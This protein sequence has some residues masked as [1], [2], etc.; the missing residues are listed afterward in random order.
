MGPGRPDPSYAGPPPE[1]APAPAWLSIELALQGILDVDDLDE[2]G[3]GELC[4]QCLHCLLLFKGIPHPD[5]LKIISFL[6]EKTELARNID[7]F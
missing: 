5:Q 4:R 3:P 6:R 7:E 1:G 2:M